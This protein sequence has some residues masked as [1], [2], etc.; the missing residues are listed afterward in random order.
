MS[1][2]GSSA[3][4]LGLGLSLVS[5]TSTLILGITHLIISNGS[6]LFLQ[7]FQSRS[8]SS[9]DRRAVGDMQRSPSVAA[10]G[11]DSGDGGIVKRA[12]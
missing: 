2:V 6:K 11:G 9:H 1:L 7:F 8:I 10:E 12:V 5:F 4:S 3:A